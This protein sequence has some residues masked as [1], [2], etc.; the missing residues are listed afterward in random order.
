[1]SGFEEVIWE[2]RTY[3][4]WPGHENRSQRVYFMATT[5]PREYLHRAV[6]AAKVGPIPAGWHVHHV[7]HD[8]LNNDPSN[9]VAISPEEHAEHHG[10]LHPAVAATCPECGTE[11]V[12]KRPWAKWCSSACK[13]RFRRSIGVAYVSPRKGPWRED[14]DCEECGAAYVA[15]R[16]W[17]RFCSSMC[18][19]R[20]ARKESAA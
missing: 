11:F 13:E 2:G 12:G 6:Y 14:R 8:P 20:H 17:A 1:M 15:K 5:A 7:D 3:R 4:R 10:R 18:K 19:Q 9:L 16:P